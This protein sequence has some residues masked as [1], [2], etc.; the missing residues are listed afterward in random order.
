M[1]RIGRQEDVEGRGIFD[2]RGQLRGGGEAEDGLYSRL[3]LK[4][5]TETLGRLAQIGCG[6]YG[7]LPGAGVAMT[8]RGQQG[9]RERKRS[10]SSL[11][12]DVERGHCPVYRIA[13]ILGRRI[14]KRNHPG[15]IVEPFD[16]DHPRN[17]RLFDRHLKERRIFHSGRRRD[18]RNNR[19]GHGFWSLSRNRRRLVRWEVSWDVSREVNRDIDRR[20]HAGRGAY[21]D[22]RELFRG[23][24]KIQRDLIRSGSYL[25]GARHGCERGRFLLEALSYPCG[26]LLRFGVDPS[27]R[28]QSV[29]D[30]QSSFK[31]LGVGLDRNEETGQRV[32]QLRR[33]HPQI[34][35]S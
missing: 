15:T 28:V 29:L 16:H 11:G 4:L 7:D 24:L 9:E 21:A 34:G 19:Y 1:L 10:G 32:G 30:A 2:L 23:E 35:G 33:D 6:R 18:S 8:G 20:L 14:G 3:S 25:N 17:G 31:A 26:S 27:F 13:S 22:A 12:K 5:R